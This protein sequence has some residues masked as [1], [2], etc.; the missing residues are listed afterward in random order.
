MASGADFSRLLSFYNNII[1][2]IFIR[3]MIKVENVKIFKEQRIMYI[4]AVQIS[5]HNQ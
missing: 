5:P 4:R 2:H 1:V 3:A